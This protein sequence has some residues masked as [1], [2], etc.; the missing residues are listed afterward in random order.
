MPFHAEI[1]K[2]PNRQNFRRE[3][4]KTQDP[5]KGGV[6]RNATRRNSGR[7]RRSELLGV[8]RHVCVLRSTTGVAAVVSVDQRFAQ[9]DDGQQQAN[10]GVVVYAVLGNV[11]VQSELC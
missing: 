11:T 4:P 6:M 8:L 10:Q 2:A 9:I 3:A 1:G 7:R 5:D